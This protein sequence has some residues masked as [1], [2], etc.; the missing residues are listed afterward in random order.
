MLVSPAILGTLSP[1]TH[2]LLFALYPVWHVPFPTPA[3]FAL[4]VCKDTCFPT[5]PVW[6]ILAVCRQ[7]YVNFVRSDISLIGEIAITV[8]PTVPSAPS[9]HQTLPM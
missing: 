9:H 3:L 7:I 6:Q 5:V 1:I 8:N 2:A 4:L